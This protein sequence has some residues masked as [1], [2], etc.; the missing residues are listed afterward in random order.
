MLTNMNS[1]KLQLDRFNCFHAYCHHYI[2]YY[3]K[4]CIL[5]QNVVSQANENYFIVYLSISFAFNICQVYSYFGYEI[6]L[7]Y[8]QN[9]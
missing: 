1:I 3:Q 4:C 9:L 2:E 7:E 8:I 6:G 5:D